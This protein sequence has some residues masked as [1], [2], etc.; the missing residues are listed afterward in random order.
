MQLVTIS[1]KRQVTLPKRYLDELGF[2]FNGKALLEKEGN[3]LTLKPVNESIIDQL[4]GSLNHL[5]DPSKLKV[6]FNV[7]R[8]KAMEEMGRNL[9]KKYDFENS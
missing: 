9:T 4:A 1:S 6:P 8:K 7:V 3:K 5:I 2:V